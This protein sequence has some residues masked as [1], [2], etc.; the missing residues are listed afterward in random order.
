MSTLEEIRKKHNIEASQSID[1]D[2]KSG[3]T[4]SDKARLVAQ[5]GLFNFSDEGIAYFRSLL[6]EEYET[7]LAEERARLADARSK[8]GS[9]KYEIGGAIIPALAAAPF[10]G[11]ASI[12]L[13]VARLAALGGT[14]ALVAG[15]GAREG[16]VVERLTKDPEMLAVETAAGAVAGPALAK[17]VKYGGKLVK[18]IAK[19]SRIAGRALTGR[20]SLPVEN[21]VRRL[22]RDVYG[23]DVPEDVAFARI[24]E[25]IGKGEIFPDISQRAATD[26]AGLYNLSGSGGQTIA[27][28]ITRR[29]EELPADA[30]ATM[31]ADLTPEVVTGNIT[32]WFGKSVDDIKKAESASYKKIFSAEDDLPLNSWWNLNLGVREALQNQKFLRNKVNA[33][34]A[35]ENKPPLFKIVDGEVRLLNSVDLE[36]AEIVRRA[37]SDK[38]TAAWRSGEGSLGKAIGGLE[39]NL[40]KIIDK[41]S[42]ELAATRAGWAK[43]K[44]LS[45][46]FEEGKKILN[47]SSEE[48]EII[49]DRVLASGDDEL[50]GALRS[51]VAFRLKTQA[52]KAA[53]RASQMKVLADENSGMRIILE[54]LYPGDSAEAAFRK[55]ELADKALK[56]QVRVTG[57]SPTAE[58]LSAADRVGTAQNVVADAAEVAV[59]GNIVGPAARFVKRIL[60]KKTKLN[61]KQL[62]QVSKI[63]ITEDPE[64][65][66]RALNNPEMLKVL[67]ERVNQAA[68]LVQRSAAGAGAYE[69]GEVVRE[70]PYIGAILGGM[71]PSSK[72]KVIRST[73]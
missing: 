38:S 70:S 33:L 36:T 68:N 57:G 19:P 4:L 7:A 40:R 54:R 72:Q 63:I 59:T 66:Q 46:I 42:P 29:A 41:A 26:V 24:V 28:V 43:V 30:R 53:G 32:K 60:G 13:T 58:R 1:I 45:E 64:I 62:A 51:G 50:I 22:A 20:L 37:L 55:I 12:P 25:R 3:L 47:K 17:G 48:A 2:E 16:D 5:G 34:M 27:N 10:T 67:I 23:A 21:E 14:Q 11:G 31:R 56:T 49:M 73:R 52:E 9:T 69:T 35:A 71:S 6:G 39:D 44:R 8:E 15:V 61:P 65:M 18:A